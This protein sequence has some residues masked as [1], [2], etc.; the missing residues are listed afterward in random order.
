MVG[1]QKI[2]TK[3][4][5]FYV[6]TK[7]FYIQNSPA[8]HNCWG[9][10]LNNSKTGHIVW[11]RNGIWKPEH[12][13]IGLLSTIWKRDMSK[14]QIPTVAVKSGYI[15]VLTSSEKCKFSLCKFTSSKF[16]RDWTL[17]HFTTL[18]LDLVLLFCSESHFAQNL[19]KLKCYI[20]LIGRLDDLG[21]D[22]AATGRSGLNI[23]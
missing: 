13:T 10:F 4:P 14:F 3:W 5:P 22:L 11:L 8:S 2:K 17:W 1:L 7:V 9:H 23:V 16:I 19:L 15:S 20:T 12:S 6:Q 18:H 21:F